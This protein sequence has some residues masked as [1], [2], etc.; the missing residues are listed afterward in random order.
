MKRRPMLKR[1][2]RQK[3]HY[4]KRTLYVSDW[5]VTPTGATTTLFGQSFVLADTPGYTD[6]T[7]LF[8]QYKINGIKVKVIP[9]STVYA[10]GTDAGMLYSVLDFNDS[11]A[12]ADV[13]ALSQ[14]ESF[15]VTRGAS[16]H[17]RYFRP[18]INVGV[19]DEAAGTNFNT[20]GWLATTQYNVP[21]YGLKWGISPSTNEIA[22]DL[23]I[24]FYIAVRNVK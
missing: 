1:T 4:F 8:D 12:P 10:S 21:H 5:Q 20:K 17:N 13:N 16:M 18:R 11:T 9:R 7:N 24:T 23:Q 15:R 3:V 22:L 2:K 14:Y 19:Y 6:L